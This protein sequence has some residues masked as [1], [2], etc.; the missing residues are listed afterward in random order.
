MA[1]KMRKSGKDRWMVHGTMGLRQ[2]RDKEKSRHEPR[3]NPREGRGRRTD[4]VD[5]LSE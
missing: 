3:K 1:G 2:K 5:R 4:Y